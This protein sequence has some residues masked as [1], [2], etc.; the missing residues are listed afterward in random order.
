MVQELIILILEYIVTTFI[1]VLEYL[2]TTKLT[3]LMR[4]LKLNS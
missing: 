4:D 1:I 2:Y 3:K